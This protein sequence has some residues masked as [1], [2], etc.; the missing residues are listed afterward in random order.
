[1]VNPF[2]CLR[3]NISRLMRPCGAQHHPPKRRGDKGSG[4]SSHALRISPLSP[5]PSLRPI[6]PTTLVYC[7]TVTSRKVTLTNKAMALVIHNWVPPLECVFDESRGQR[8]GVP[9]VW[10]TR[11]NPTGYY[12]T[13]SHEKTTREYSSENGEHDRYHAIYQVL[14]A[15]SGAD[16]RK[17][18]V[19]TV[20]A[21]R[22]G[23]AQSEEWRIL[24]RERERMGTAV[25]AYDRSRRRP[26][27]RMNRIK[28]PSIHHCPE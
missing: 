2:V 17:R 13:N 22:E 28:I 27:M 18:F 12:S 6:S 26:R 10:D 4:S 3:Q 16:Q 19:R 21:G 24:Q 23:K 5:L 8:T 1:M 25:L 11:E 15:C 7:K 9:N 14:T 20:R